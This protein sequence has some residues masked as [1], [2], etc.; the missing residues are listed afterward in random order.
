MAADRPRSVVSVALLLL[1]AFAAVVALAEK[2]SQALLAKQQAMGGILPPAYAGV[3]RLANV[4]LA[5]RDHVL[6]HWFLYGTAAL[7][8]PA[9]LL[10]GLKRLSATF[11]RWREEMAGMAFRKASYDLRR[12]ES[13]LR[14]LLLNNPDPHHQVVLGIDERGRPVY[15]TDR[16][17]S[18]HIHCLGQTGSGKTRSVIEPLIF[19]DL[20][21]HRGVIVV[22]G[23]GAQE[24]EERLA[25]MAAAAVRLGDLKVFTLN[26]FRRRTPTTRST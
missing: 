10:R 12:V 24:N 21:R 22:D 11:G 7:L 15:L 4:Y 18:M 26:P 19:Q 20:V 6:R 13:S 8:V 9:A 25:A 5:V 1:I 3:A 16:A 17:R 23:K 2:G 14:D